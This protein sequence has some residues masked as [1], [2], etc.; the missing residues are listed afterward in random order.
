RKM[1]MDVAHRIRDGEKVTNAIAAVA[2]E[3]CLSFESVRAAYYAEKRKLKDA[4]PDGF[5]SKKE[6]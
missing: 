6:G 1:F 5:L 4:L 3:C 2:S